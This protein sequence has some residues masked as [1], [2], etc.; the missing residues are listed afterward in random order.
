MFSEDARAGRGKQAALADLLSNMQDISINVPGIQT[1]NVSGGLRPSAMG[2]TGR[3]AMAEMSKQAL[4]ALMSGDQF[5][6]GQILR[7]PQIT[8][9]AQAGGL[10]K[11][12]DW[13]SLISSIVGGVGKSVQEPGKYSALPQGDDLGGSSYVDPNIQRLMR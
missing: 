13:A 4:Q 8:P 12:L 9:P 2:A 3:S 5:T 11:G 7:G 10:E 1:A 6:G